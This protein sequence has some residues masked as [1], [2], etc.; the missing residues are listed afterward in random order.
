MWKEGEILDRCV[1]CGAMLAYG[2]AVCTQCGR[3]R[4]ATGASYHYGNYQSHA[5]YTAPQNNNPVA[6]GYTYPTYTNYSGYSAA[7]QYSYAPSPYWPSAA[8]LPA[9]GEKE[10]PQEEAVFSTK[11][12]LQYLVTGLLPFMGLLLVL[13]WAFNGKVRT[14]KKNL[15]KAMLWIHGAG[16][17]LLLCGLCIWVILLAQNSMAPGL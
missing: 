14:E 9:E 12:Y 6:P 8:L 2:Q 7:P 10:M 13:Q 11:E 16:L 17:L 1:H 3:N 15:G 4:Y 5:P